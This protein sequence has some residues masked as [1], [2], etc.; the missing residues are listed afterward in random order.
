VVPVS[1]LPIP[2]AKKWGDNSVLIFG[3]AFMLVASLVKINY[4][5][6]QAQNREQYYAGS[7]LFFSSTLVAEMASISI[8]AK[9]IPSHL[10]MSFWNAGLFS[11]SADNLGRA[12]G[13]ALYTLYTN[14]SLAKE[15]TIAYSVT[16]G[17]AALFL[18]FTII[19]YRR[20][21]QHTEIFVQTYDTPLAITQ[22]EIPRELKPTIG[23]Q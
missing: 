22:K 7:I 15:P 3:M 16:A 11:G 21:V 4:T 18:V 23:V 6:D 10:K 2:A 19:L 8:L 5:P 20:L 13:S 14:A 9:V 1:L 17:L 12:V